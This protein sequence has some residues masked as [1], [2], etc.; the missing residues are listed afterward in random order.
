LVSGR[1]SLLF[2]RHQVRVI[3]RPGIA[4]LFIPLNNIPISHQTF[5][6]LDLTH[7]LWIYFIFV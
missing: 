5:S 2:N 6:G 4:R 3:N 7:A 1:L